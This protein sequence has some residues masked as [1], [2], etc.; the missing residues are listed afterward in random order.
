MKA[1]ILAA[2]EGNRLRPL[3]SDRPKCMVEFRSK[4]IIDHILDTM[5]KARVHDIVLVKGYKADALKREGTLEAINTDF[6]STNMVETL[7][8]ARDH[9]KD[10]DIIISYGDIVFDVSILEALLAEKAPLSTVVSLN[11]RELWEQRMENP[12]DDAET[13]KM[14]S[15][16]HITELGKK[17]KSFDEIEGQYMGLIKVRRDFLGTF[18]HFYDSLDRQKTYDG[19]SFRNMYMTSF[20]QAFIDAGHPVKAVK[21]T[22]NWYEFDSLQDLKAAENLLA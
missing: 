9:F 7:F 16:G 20:L 8:C 6:A 3:T 12:L 18:C 14:N 17:P 11:W 19:K 4:P 15:A 10:D 2:G 21:V 5:R 22:G 1:V 13:L